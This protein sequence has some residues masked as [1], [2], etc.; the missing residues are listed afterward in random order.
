MSISDPSI[1][2]WLDQEDQRTAQ[3]IRKHGTYNQYVIGDEDQRHP[4]FAYTIGLFGIGH[5]ELLIVGVDHLTAGAV[6]NDV[7]ARVRGGADL[8]P[9]EILGFDGWQHRALVEVVP[10][11]GEIVFGANRFFRRPDEA[12]VPVY[13]LTLDDTGGRFPGQTGY[14]R[15]A[16][17]QPR[18][19]EL[20]A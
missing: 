16:W 7:A 13:Q 12:S 20:R 18:P 4:S 6:L 2:A 9:G 15:P 5:P 11:P 8:V 17:V 14:A 3:I 1:Q 10:N 19:G